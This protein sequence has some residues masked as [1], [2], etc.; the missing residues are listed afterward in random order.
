MHV[1]NYRGNRAVVGYQGITS[2]YPQ[3]VQVLIDGK[4]EYSPLFGGVNWA[5]F[6]LMIEDIERIEVVRGPN[7][8]TFGSNAFQSVINITTTHSSQVIGSQLKHTQGERGYRRT[9][10]AT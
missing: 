8:A 3:G 4:S 2:E 10:S 9:L 7:N 1:G 6:P 5:N